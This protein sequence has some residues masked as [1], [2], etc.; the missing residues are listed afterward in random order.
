MGA[1]RRNLTNDSH[2]DWSPSWSP[3]GQPHRLRVPGAGS[4][5]KAEIYAIDS[6]G[7]NSPPPD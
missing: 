2:W 7:S 4:Y 5:G 3:D 6:D 1:I